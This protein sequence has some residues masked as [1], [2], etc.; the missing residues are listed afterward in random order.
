MRAEDTI[1]A[2][3]SGALP[4]GIAVLRVSGPAARLAMESLAG[5]VPD[6]RRASLRTF[7]DRSGVPIDRGL[8]LFF[9]GP[10]SVSGEDLAEFHVHGGRAVAAAMLAA[11][12]GISGVRLAEAGEFT[13][14][15]FE[16]GRIDLTEAEGL[17]D[18][19]AAETEGQRAR[20]MAQAGGSL[21]QL[22]D[23]WM[24]RL[25]R[26]RALIEAAFDFSDEGDVADDVAGGVAAE[27]AAL[28]GEM[29]RSLAEA[30]RGE[31]WRDG[32]H[33]VIAGAPNAG[34]S[35]LLNALA[36]RE[37]AIVSPVPGT[38]RDVIE[39]RLDLGG[40]PVRFSDT[41]GL[42]AADDAVEAIGVERARAALRQ[43]DLVLQLVAPGEEAGEL[44][45]EAPVLRLR[46]KRDLAPDGPPPAGFDL[47]L[48]AR[49]GEGIDA[50]VRRVA[51]AAREAAGDPARAVPAR[52]R[53]REVVAG[54]L[55][56]LDAYDP[57][58]QPAE[59]AAETLRLAADR[60]GALT[61]RRGVEDLLGVIFGEFCIGK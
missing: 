4:A 49:T 48:S 5:G 12:T 28:A 61:G 9:P 30:R 15:A 7:R 29:R 50:L 34:K 56:H 6:P 43:A 33:V 31:I 36:E 46:T 52:L 60:L 22:A 45:G 58:H 59:V 37:V 20:A 19:L 41:A 16:N 3:S 55:A 54:T 40:V 25:L 39:T 51:D 42:R 57:L 13:R 38:T 53:Q 23:A 47:A 10:G 32:F 18:L 8:L 35:S 21:R 44:E 2:L 17:A 24:A 1:A 14:R 11:L 26:A 27:V